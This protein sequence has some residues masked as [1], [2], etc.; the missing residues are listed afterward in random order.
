MTEGQYSAEKDLLKLIENPGEAES[1][2]ARALAG[3]PAGGVLKKISIFSFLKKREKTAGA[4]PHVKRG[5]QETLTDRKFI[6]KI[7]FITTLC[8]AIYFVATIIRE[9][10]RSKNTRI[11]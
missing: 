4:A 11:S 5:F 2:K 8:V 1:Q 9:Y 7:L 10:V 6:L 3:G